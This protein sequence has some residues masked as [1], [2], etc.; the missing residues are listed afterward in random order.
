MSSLDCALTSGILKACQDAISGV[1]EIYVAKHSDATDTAPTVVDGE[2]TVI[3]MALGTQF[4]KYEFEPETANAQSVLT[5]DRKVGS[6][7]YDETVNIMLNYSTKEVANQ[8]RLLAKNDLFVIVKQ[9][10]GDFEAYGFS[11]GLTLSS[12]TR[13]TGTAL[14]ERN[15]HELVLTGRETTL[16]Y[17]VSSSIIAGL[18]V[19]AS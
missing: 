15:G 16:P 7:A 10:D 4:Y 5:L 18:L 19:P 8:L 1:D 6:P 9:R 14:G 13:L 12:G 17:K 11:K 2:I 3:S